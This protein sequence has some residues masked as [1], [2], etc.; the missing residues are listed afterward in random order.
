M[1]LPTRDQGKA[2]VTLTEDVASE[3]HMVHLDIQV[4][5]D[6][7]ALA[8]PTL[9]KRLFQATLLSI[10]RENRRNRMV[11]EMFSFFYLMILGVSFFS[12]FLT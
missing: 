5:G 6:E 8:N 11:A 3:G 7:S 4:P 12:F 9:A 2:P 1:G 10:D